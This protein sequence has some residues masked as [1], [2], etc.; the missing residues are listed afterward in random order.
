MKLEM[1]VEVWI[2]GTGDIHPIIAFDATYTTRIPHTHILT[3]CHYD[4]KSGNNLPA[5]SA[6][7]E[8][9]TGMRLAPTRDGWFWKVLG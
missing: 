9:G 2:D 3:V 8:E 7:E 4:W 5:L 1:W 6:E